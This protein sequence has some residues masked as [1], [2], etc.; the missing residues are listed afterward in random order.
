MS[1]FDFVEKGKPLLEWWNRAYWLN[2]GEGSS[3]V[4]LITMK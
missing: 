4:V 3:K 2:S 1:L